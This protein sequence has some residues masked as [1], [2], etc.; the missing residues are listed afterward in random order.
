VEERVHAPQP[1]QTISAPA[2]AAAVAAP[3]AYADPAGAAAPAE[4]AAGNWISLLEVEAAQMLASNS[5]R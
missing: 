4:A 1:A 2:S 5:R 3:V